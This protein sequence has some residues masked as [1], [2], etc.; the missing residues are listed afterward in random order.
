MSAIRQAL[1]KLDSAVGKLEGSTNTL[2]TSIEARQQDMFGSANGS[3]SPAIVA[4]KLDSAIQKVES[5]L[6][7]TA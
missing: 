2:E 1:A 6:K 7:E 5:V 3:V 4:Q